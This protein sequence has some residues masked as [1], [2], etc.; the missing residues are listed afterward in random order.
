MKRHSMSKASS[1][2][3]FTRGAVKTH[4]KNL[5]GSP[6]RGGIRL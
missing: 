6:M 5:A 3:S 2:K 4:Y 1:R